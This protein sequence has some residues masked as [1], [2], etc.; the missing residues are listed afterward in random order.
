MLK[1]AE[2][3]IGLIGHVD[4]G[5]TSIVEAITGKWV[6]THSEEIKRG[7]SIRLGYADIGIYSITKKKTKRF[8]ASKN[9]KDPKTGEK[10]KLERIVSF[11][12]AP[13][14]ENLMTTMLSGASIMHGA[15]LVIAANESCP[16]PQTIEHLTAIKLTGIKNLIV[17]QNKIDLVTKEQAKKNYKEI[18]KFL[19]ENNFE[20]IEVIPTAAHFKANIDKIIEAIQKNIPTPK[21]DLKKTLKMYCARSFDINKPGTSPKKIKGGVLGGTILQGTALKGMKIEIGPGN[22]GQSIKTRIVNIKSSLG[23][24]EKA[25]PGGLI[26]IETEL[27]PSICQS[28]QMKGQVITEAGKLGKPTNKVTVKAFLIKR[29]SGKTYELKKNSK[30][31]LTIG[32]MSVLSTIT[33]HSKEKTEFLTTKPVI[34]D[35]DTKI[36]ISM[37]ENLKWRLAGYGI[38]T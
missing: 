38:P 37:Q 11:L 27:D 21:F 1:Q 18:R 16:Q 17:I 26:A 28:D 24:I 20:N 4:T 23:Q 32:T 2:V 12:D 31:V 34:Y 36:A 22:K 33:F 9:G 14:H 35:K 6:D 30:A 7:I 13:G 15:I 8:F 29:M 10:G 19:K 3:N 5:K 25:I